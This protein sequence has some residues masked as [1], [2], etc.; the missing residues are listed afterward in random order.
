M[1]YPVKLMSDGDGMEMQPSTLVAKNDFTTSDQTEEI[2]VF[3]EDS[4]AKVTVGVWRC[5]PCRETFEAYPVD[6]MMQI[7][8]GEL[9]LTSPDGAV[10]VYGPG[11]TFFMA[12]GTPVVWEIRK[13]LRKYFMIS[14]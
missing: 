5:A 13:T 12:K 2:H 1:M 4:E 7:L 14:E 6:E 10:Q 8:E 3:H 9:V 11:D